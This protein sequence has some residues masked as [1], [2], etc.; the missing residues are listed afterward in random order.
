MRLRR[1]GAG[2]ASDSGPSG[3]RASR[4]RARRRPQ[5]RGEQQPVAADAVVLACTGRGGRGRA[6]A[7][8]LVKEQLADR[9]QTAGAGR[10]LGDRHAL[11]AA[12]GAVRGRGR[13]RT[14]QA[15][16]VGSPATSRETRADWRGRRDA[17]SPSSS[18][19]RPGRERERDAG[20][21]AARADPGRAEAR[22]PPVHGGAR[23]GAVRPA[24]RERRAAARPA[25]SCVR[26]PGDPGTSGCGSR[27][28]LRCAPLA[29][30]VTPA[31]V[32]AAGIGTRL[33][34]LTDVTRSPSCR[35]TGVP[36]IGCSCASLRT[37][38]ARRSRSSSA[39][40]QS[41]SSGS[42]ATAAVSA[43]MCVTRRVSRPTA[44]LDAVLAAAPVQPPYLV[45]GADM[46]FSP[47]DVGRFAPLRGLRRAPPERSLSVPEPG[48][49]RVGTVSSRTRPRRGCSRPRRCG[50]LR[51]RS[52][53]ILDARPGTAPWEFAT[54]FQQA[55]DAGERDL[56]I[57]IAPTRGLTTP[58]DLDPRRTSRTLRSS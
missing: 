4:R 8:P 7:I 21:N 37:R 51:R 55:I 42:S 12:R 18:P 29:P 47:G 14:D 38:A 43:P 24:G 27:A 46:L 17:S 44:R 11:D 3:G 52:L 10:G 53:P 9:A 50:G 20:R 32:I 19:T 28:R 58:L 34:P 22:R 23:R 41:R 45:V 57:E 15:R 40:S 39:T 36:V 26:S 16:P 5:R 31:V 35:S 2:R 48:T 1:V 54:A 33:R 13:D 30:D 49:V 6:A 25:P 56:G